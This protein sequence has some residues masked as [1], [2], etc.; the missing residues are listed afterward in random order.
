MERHLISHEH[1][2][3]F[4]GEPGL[5]FTKDEK[6]SIMINEEDHVRLQVL[7]PGLSVMQSW[8]TVSRLD[9][10][11]NEYLEF[12]Y[13]PN[14]GYLTACPTN[15]GTGLRVS[16]LLHLPGLVMTDEID[17]L[18]NGLSRMGLSARG[19]YGEGTKPVGDIYQI[20]NAVTLGKTEKSIIDNLEKVI[21][22]ISRY[23]KEAR[24]KIL[25]NKFKQNLEDKIYRAYGIL[26]YAKL[27]D[28]EEAML[29][30]SKLKLGV[31]LKSKL[32]I[33]TDFIDQLLFIIQPA[34]L[35]ELV[36]RELAVSQRDVVRTELIRKN[37]LGN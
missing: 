30:I 1:A 23:E 14:F 6:V 13:H 8:E 29:H 24:K 4:T 34:H 12:G 20:S 27:I 22:S 17:R 18:I 2:V 5:I 11:L 10:R 9:D 25:E 7:N 33:K 3:K 26:A 31:Y 36:G 21:H 28:S 19:F 15:V 37:L 32:P 35:Q 16:C